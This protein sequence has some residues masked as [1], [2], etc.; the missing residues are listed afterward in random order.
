MSLTDYYQTDIN[1]LPGDAVAGM[2]A[3]MFLTVTSKAVTSASRSLWF[4]RGAP[5]PGWSML[6]SGTHANLVFSVGGANAANSP[7]APVN[8]ADLNRAILVTGILDTGAGL[9]RMY[10]NRAQV[11]VGTSLTGG[12]LPADTRRPIVGQG[13]T[14]QGVIVHGVYFAVGTPSLHQYRAQ[15]DWVMS[16]GRMQIVPGFPGTC[17]DFTDEVTAAGGVLP[18]TLTDRSTGGL[19]FTKVGAPVL[20]D[21]KARAFSY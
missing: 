12:Y 3:S 10:K 11:G 17:L 7:S 6:I 18:T 13:D 19:I 15:C 1:A 14:S 2:V 4:Q 9:V 8:D 21:V 20:R 5:N 16:T